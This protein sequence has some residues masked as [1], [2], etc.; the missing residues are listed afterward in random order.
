MILPHRR[1]LALAAVIVGC[2]LLAAPPTPAAANVMEE[3]EEDF[4]WTTLPDPAF[5]TYQFECGEGYPAGWGCY[6]CQP[7]LGNEW[8]AFDCEAG[9]Y[10]NPVAAC[11]MGGCRMT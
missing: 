5:C 9:D 7:L 2:A 8:W 4:I 11:D 6:H 1:T 3:C 10:S